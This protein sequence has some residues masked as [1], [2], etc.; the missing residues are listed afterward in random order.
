[1][2]TL[3]LLTVLLVAKALSLSRFDLP[4]SAWL[5]PAVLWQDLIVVLLYALIDR[6]TRRH[7][8]IGWGIYGLLVAYAA[9]N[10]PVARLF[11]TP[12]TWPMMRAARGTLADSIAYQLTSVTLLPAAIVLTTGVVLPLILRRRQFQLPQRAQTAALT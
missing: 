10:V 7:P 8:A 4:S 6:G 5:L 1:M 12:L 2:K 9:V 11:A 3:S